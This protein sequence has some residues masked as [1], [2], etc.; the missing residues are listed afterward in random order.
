MLRYN[1][2]QSAVF[3]F[4]RISLLPC[5]YC[6][7]GQVHI[8]V[9]DHIPN[10]GLSC[11]ALGVGERTRGGRG[12][13]RARGRISRARDC[14]GRD[15][16]RV[17]LVRGT[18]REREPQV[19][20]RQLRALLLLVLAQP[21]VERHGAHADAV[22]VVTPEYNGSVPGVLKNAIDWLSRPFGD[23]AI[24][25][26]PLAVV[27][28]AHGRYGGVWAHDETRKSFGLAGARVVEEWCDD[29]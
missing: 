18:A 2:G 26:K 17:S 11:T 6:F 10:S 14:I 7:R 27:G 23:G 20:A 16:G 19:E 15:R 8:Q 24:K 13:S 5:F 9:S 1:Y 29:F 22:L 3:Y 25:G 28:A 12:R 21:P 4:F